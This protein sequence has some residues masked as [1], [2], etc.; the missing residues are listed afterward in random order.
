MSI[1]WTSNRTS[2]YFKPEELLPHGFTDITV[3]DPIL[4]KVI[5]EIRELLNV[6]CTINADGRNWCGFRTKDCPIGAP[7]SQHK[8]GKAADLHPIGMSAEKGREIIKEAIS[9]GKLSEVGGIELNV[10][11]I[12]VDI[13]PRING[14]VLYFTA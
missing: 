14:K 10:S 6:P 3:L 7:K 5:D 12:H 4:L 11:W 13:R 8:Q 9:Q 1:K 2:K